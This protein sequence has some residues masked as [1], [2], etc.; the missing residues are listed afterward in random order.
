MSHFHNIMSRDRKKGGIADRCNL[1][2]RLKTSPLGQFALAFHRRDKK[3]V[4]KAVISYPRVLH[5]RPSYP[6]EDRWP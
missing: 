5:L 3:R 6:S 4:P 2:A 1:A